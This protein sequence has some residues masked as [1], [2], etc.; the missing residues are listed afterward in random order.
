[1]EE[2][3]NPCRIFFEQNAHDQNKVE[4]LQQQSDACKW[5]ELTASIFSC[6]P[7]KSEEHVLRLLFNPIH[8]DMETMS[9]KPP[10]IN[11]V[12]DKGCSVDRLQL[13]SKEKCIKDGHAFAATKNEL[14]PEKSRRSLCGV[15]TLSVH[16]VRNIVDN[17][18]NRGFGVYDT[19]LDNN[20]AHADICQLIA[21][22]NKSDAR[23]VRLQL[24]ALGDKG[25]EVV[26]EH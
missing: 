14:N 9:L 17:N 12:K 6:S 25:F 13:T 7:V 16:E 18:Q 3:I 10:A 23:S 11:D 24:M 19:A 2:C 4:L 5:E 1:M 26:D 22:K 20:P 15:T 8:L 21:T